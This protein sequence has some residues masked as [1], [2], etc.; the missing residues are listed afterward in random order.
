M[1]EL[2]EAIDEIAA[3]AGHTEEICGHSPGEGLPCADVRD[4]LMRAVRQLSPLI[5][6]V[7]LLAAADEIRDM[8]SDHHDPGCSCWMAGADAAERVLRDRAGRTVAS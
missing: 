1:S 5:E 2:A 4:D 8:P 7:A 3:R 6:R